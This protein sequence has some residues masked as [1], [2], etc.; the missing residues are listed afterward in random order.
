[1]ANTGD[2]IDTLALTNGV[3]D[4][5]QFNGAI[6]IKCSWTLV[7]MVTKKLEF[8]QKIGYNLANTVDTVDTLALTRGFLRSGNLMLS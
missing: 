6:E 1:L 3:L 7:A 2:K 4:V 5:G 8:Q